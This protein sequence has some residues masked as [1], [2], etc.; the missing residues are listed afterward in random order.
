MN[1]KDKKD[2]IRFRKLE[3]D[4]LNASKFLPLLEALFKFLHSA[5]ESEQPMMTKM[6]VKMPDSEPTELLNLWVTAGE[7]TP[8]QRIEELREENKLLKEQLE[9]VLTGKV[10]G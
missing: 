7:Q 6:M 4:L 3:A 9:I 5:T 10:K 1:E 8:F 2:L